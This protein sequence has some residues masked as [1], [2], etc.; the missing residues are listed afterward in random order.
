[1]E[2]GGATLG[3]LVSLRGTLDLRIEGLASSGSVLESFTK[4]M[5]LSLDLWN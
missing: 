4:F 5:F 1:M 3:K 2:R